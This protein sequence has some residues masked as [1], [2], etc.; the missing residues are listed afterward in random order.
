M[1][2]KML[3]HQN[4]NV[5]T[6]ELLT[7]NEIIAGILENENQEIENDYEGKTEEEITPTAKETL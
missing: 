2:T 4:K 1:S 3:L 7:D 6:S 5:S